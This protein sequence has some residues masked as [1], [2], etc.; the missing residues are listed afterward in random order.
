M[1]YVCDES[2]VIKVFDSEEKACAY[3]NDHE[4][5]W[6]CCDGDDCEPSWNEDEGYDP[7]MGD[8]SW[9]CQGGVKM[10]WVDEET[11]ETLKRLQSKSTNSDDDFAYCMAIAAVE[12]MSD[13]EYVNDEYQERIWS[14]EEKIKEYESKRDTD[15]SILANLIKEN[16]NLRACLRKVEEYIIS[17]TSIVLYPYDDEA[18]LKLVQKTLGKED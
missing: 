9:D 16:G 3:A 5:T 4:D 12:K 6:V 14:L 8:Y 13:M 7:Y 15:V 2:G 18:M 17:K 11:I 1:W 10:N